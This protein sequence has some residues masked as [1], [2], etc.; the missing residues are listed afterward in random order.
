MNEDKEKK[1]EF[2]KCDFKNI[3]K[4]E[5]ILTNSLNT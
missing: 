2:T 1:A 3:L 5:Q 4:L